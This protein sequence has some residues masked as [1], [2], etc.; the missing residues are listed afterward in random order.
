MV[1]R[2]PKPSGSI[3]QDPDAKLW[4][5]LH[6]FET[7]L[8]SNLLL[9]QAG[10]GGLEVVGVLPIRW[11]RGHPALCHILHDEELHDA[12]ATGTFQVALAY[13]RGVKAKTL[14][15]QLA[16]TVGGRAGRAGPAD[17]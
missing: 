7:T 12:M 1:L 8:R 14:V 9:G 16:S 3:L 11:A 15:D 2:V 5:Q 6:Q 13:R 10:W 4:D 17:L